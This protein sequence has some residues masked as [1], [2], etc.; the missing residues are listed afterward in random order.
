[1][2][3]KSKGIQ[4]EAI[5]KAHYEQQGYEILEQN[6]RYRR[7]EID[8]IVHKHHF[9]VFVEVKHRSTMDFGAPE[10]FVSPAQEERI[11]EAAEDYIYAI[12]WK[13]GI[14]FDIVCVYK[15]GNVEVIEDAF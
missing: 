3:S 1:M 5:A 14:R 6:Y 7:S 9:L 13:K 12:R 15:D 10:S 4:G 11:R 8:L 2:D